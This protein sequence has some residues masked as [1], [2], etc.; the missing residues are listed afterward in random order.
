MTDAVQKHEQR[1]IDAARRYAL[2]DASDP[3]ALGRALCHIRQGICRPR[4][5]ASEEYSLLIGAD[6]AYDATP[7]PE[8]RN[9]YV[10]TVYH[11]RVRP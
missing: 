5:K 11:N 4:N 3:F 8:Q 9:G 7:V 6:A 1:L 2:S 10:A